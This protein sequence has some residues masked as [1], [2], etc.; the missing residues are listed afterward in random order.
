MDAPWQDPEL[1]DIF[2][3]VPIPDDLQVHTRDSNNWG[4]DSPV[5]ILQPSRNRM[6]ELYS[7]YK[8]SPTYHQDLYLQ[9]VKWG[10]GWGGY[11]DDVSTNAASWRKAGWGGAATRI[12]YIAGLPRMEEVRAQRIDHVVNFVLPRPAAAP[13]CTWPAKETDG[14][15]T[16]AD[17]IP[18]GTRFRLPPTLNVDA[19]PGFTNPFAKAV[20]KAAQ[21]YGIMLTDRDGRPDDTQ[22][23]AMTFFAE[24]PHDLSSDPYFG[25]NGMLGPA[26]GRPDV[27]RYFPF[28][29]L[30]VV[31]PPAGA[32]CP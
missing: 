8:P 27:F 24:R 1:T 11:M 15:Y 17:A 10:A 28:D 16:A 6:W 13:K 18:E 19:I 31:A 32:T 14:W 22:L 30:Q 29:Q 5:I 2:S 3:H 23:Y 9:G 12:P 7:L 4:W 20:A 25:T 26:N 21:R